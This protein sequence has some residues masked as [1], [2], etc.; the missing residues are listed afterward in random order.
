MGNE[1]KNI[2]NIVIILQQTIEDVIA[3]RNVTFH[4]YVVNVIDGHYGVGII[5]LVYDVD[6]NLIKNYF[7]NMSYN[8]L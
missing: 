1:I 4:D 2:V 6:L 3:V 5:L 8:D 7:Y